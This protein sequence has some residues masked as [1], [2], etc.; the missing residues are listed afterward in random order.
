MLLYRFEDGDQVRVIRNVRNDGTYPGAPRGELLIKRGSIGYVVD[1]GT[2]L[3]D[4]IIYA[5][6]FLE[7]DVVVGCREEELILGD[8][9]WTPSRFEFRDRVVPVK[10]LGI[11]GT[12]LVDAGETGEVMKVLR[13][14][15]GQFSYHVYF[16]S[17]VRTLQVP[18]PSLDWAQPSSTIKLTS[19]PRGGNL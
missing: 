9:P 14:P 4:Q 15:N 16:P 19:C 17:I 1:M 3:V 6:H 18:E 7:A 5:V 8:A 10:A 12:V 2:F 11:N 13:D